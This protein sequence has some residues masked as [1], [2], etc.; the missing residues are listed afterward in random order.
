MGVKVATSPLFIYGQTNAEKA[1]F[2]IGF[3]FSELTDAKEF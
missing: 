2:G 1:L 3:K